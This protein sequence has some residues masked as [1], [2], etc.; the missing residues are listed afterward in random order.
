MSKE[1]QCLLMDI[2]DVIEK[3]TIVFGNSTEHQKLAERYD[4]G[5]YRPMF[6][7]VNRDNKLLCIWCRNRERHRN[8]KGI[9]VAEPELARI[10]VRDEGFDSEEWDA[11]T[12]KVMHGLG[13][14]L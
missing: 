5:D 14:K 4:D 11:L 8:D 13:L 3:R 6:S 1:F 10:K 9:L 12:L 2:A 7:I